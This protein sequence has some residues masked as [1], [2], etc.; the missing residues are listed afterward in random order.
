MGK[1]E[2]VLIALFLVAGVVVY[3]VTAPPPPPGTDVSVGGIFQRIQRQLHAARE[4]AT[5]TST[6]NVPLGSDVTTVRIN[7]PRPCDLTITG[8]DRDDIAIEV[9]TTARGYT[10]EEAKAAANAAA[11]TG[12]TRGDATVL[13]GIWED[14]R[15]P[16]G[17]FRKA[18][19]ITVPRRLA[20]GPHRRTER[21]ERR[22]AEDISSRGKRTCSTPRARCS[23]PTSAARSRSVAAPT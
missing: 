8:A 19:T 9:K 10:Q 21:V 14:D 16:A 12:E 22:F 18:V 13:T 20:T 11:V 4:T 2:L 15:G 23:S 3:Q 1:R 7:L 17:S 5:G 6:Q